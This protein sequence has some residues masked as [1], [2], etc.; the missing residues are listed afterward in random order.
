MVF[1]FLF[2]FI[3]YYVMVVLVSCKQTLYIWIII[4]EPEKCVLHISV[5]KVVVFLHIFILLYID[6]KL[7]IS[8]MSSVFI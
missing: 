5:P 2:N 1:V 3:V 8:S 6:N 7:P 4:D